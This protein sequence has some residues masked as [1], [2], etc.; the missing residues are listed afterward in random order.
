[1]NTKVLDIIKDTAPVIAGYIILGIGFGILMDANGYNIIFSIAMSVFIYAG[2]MQYVAVGL[3]T[4]GASYLAVIL[5]TLAVNARHLFYGISMINKY[6]SAGIKKPYQIFALTDETYSLVCNSD[7][8]TDYYFKVSF[9]NQIYW[10]TGTIIG[11]ILGSTLDFNS[12]GIDFS[13]TALFVTVFMDQWLK[14]KKHFAAIVGIVCSIISLLIFGKSNFLIPAM[15][16]IA[17]IL[18]LPIGGRTD[19]DN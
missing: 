11:S 13:L 2:S 16:A 19:D 8:G 7:K 18:L 5:T 9:F 15:I 17:V 14:T 1:M 12:K 4:G 6:K 3:F 10:V